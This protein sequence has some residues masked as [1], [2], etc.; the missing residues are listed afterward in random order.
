M[1]LQDLLARVCFEFGDPMNS[2]VH[3]RRVIDTVKYR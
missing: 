3:I 2:L 1:K